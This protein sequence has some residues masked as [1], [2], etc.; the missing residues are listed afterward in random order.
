M[1]RNLITFSLLVNICSCGCDSQTIKNVYRAHNIEAIPD[2]VFTMKELRVLSIGPNWIV[3][4]PIAGFQSEPGIK[5]IL[6][7]SERICD[8]NKLEIL[9]INDQ[10]IT[11]LPPCVDD[12]AHLQQLDLSF[13]EHFDWQRFLPRLTKMKNLRRLVLFGISSAMKD[14]TRVREGV[15]RNI[16]LVLTSEE[17]DRLGN[18]DK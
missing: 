1:I 15:P 9:N 6:N 12:L 14:S 5:K 7:V 3:N 2:S 10:D 4:A 17:F 16:E 11:S 13:N 8:L 18:S